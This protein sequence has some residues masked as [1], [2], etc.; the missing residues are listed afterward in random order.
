MAG[1]FGYKIH[2]NNFDA[3][4]ISKC[5]I[6][7]AQQ[8]FKHPTNLISIHSKKV[9][10]GFVMPYGDTSWPLK[11][12][13]GNYYFQLFGQIILPNETKLTSKNFQNGFLNP[14]LKSKHEFLLKL[15]GAFVFTLYDK[16]AKKFTL[17]NDPFG[18]FSLYYF[19]DKRITIFASQLHAITEIINDKQWNEE[20]LG[21]YLGLGFSMNGLTIYKNI[22][23]LQPAEIVTLSQDQIHSENYYTPNYTADGNIKEETDN[24]KNAVISAID[25]QLKNNSS[26]GA[27][28]TGGFDSRVTWSI[29]K[30]LNGLDK[31]TSFTHGLPDSRDIHVAKKL[32][33]MLGIAHQV[34][35]FD[36]AFIKHLPE[37]WEPFV[38]MTE[39][40]VPITAAHALDSWKF[41]QNHYQLLLDSHG[42]ALY[43]R[44]YMKVAEKRIDDSK[45]FAEQFFNFTKSG[46]VKLNV[47]KSDI[48]QNAIKHSLD[49]LN[50]YF[51]SIKH[52]KYKGDKVDLF[53][54]HQVSANKY[55]IAGTVQ[56][57]WLLLSHPFL[58]LDA[59]KAVQKIPLHYRQNHSIYQYIIN[60][61]FPQMKKIWMENMGMPAP[62]Y[63]FVYL[64]YVP[65]IYELLLQKSVARISESLYKILTVRYFVTDYDLFFRI[66]F[67][68]V[69]EILMRPNDTFYELVDKKKVEDLI[70]HAEL[71]P[72]FKVS[73]LSD[74]ITLKLFFDTICSN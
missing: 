34:K 70:N 74:L 67:A 14:F 37:L 20:G 42:G 61:T 24:I 30:H 56:M 3:S 63:G 69:K 60:H 23:R 39:G 25:A 35:I 73:S 41:G 7:H 72:N 59:F 28:I 43:R 68:R 55:S 12:D 10:L 71:N 5:L 51:D 45:S 2:S 1:I 32:A 26:I 27:A 46:L 48:Q 57:N 65:M 9:G 66:N 19:S 47:L 64:R 29:I 11:S 17:V 49:G 54:I 8:D 4:K 40:Q 18:N 16:K 6:Q 50:I 58:N 13:D 36:E 21:Q 31:V 22:K 53:Y 44:Q 15:Q 33:N 62:Y 52:N 38:K